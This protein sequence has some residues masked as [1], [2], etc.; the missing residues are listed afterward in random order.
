VWSGSAAP[1]ATMPDGRQAAEALLAA[2]DPPDALFCVND[3]MAF[4]ALDVARRR[5]IDVPGA[6]QVIGFDDIP[7]AAWE[8]YRLTSFRQDPALMAEKALELLARRRE[9]PELAPMTLRL[10][11]DLVC[12]G[13][14]RPLP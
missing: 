13:T 7:E 9:A 5:G 12:R 10:A 6:L 14:T 8:A 2:A 4:G 11:A 3:L 1:T